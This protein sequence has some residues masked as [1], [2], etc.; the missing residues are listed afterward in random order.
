MHDFARLIYSVNLI[1]TFVGHD[2]VIIA[3]RA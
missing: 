2:E 1:L 3:L